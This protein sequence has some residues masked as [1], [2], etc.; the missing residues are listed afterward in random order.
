MSIQNENIIPRFVRCG[1]W[2]NSSFQASKQ[3][4][5]LNEV[6]LFLGK[7]PSICWSRW[8]A[9]CGSVTDTGLKIVRASQR[10]R[11]RMNEIIQLSHTDRKKES[12]DELYAFDV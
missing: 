9:R 4:D 7:V 11:K 10:E 6:S 8:R 2:F 3:V 12:D 1:C 5:T